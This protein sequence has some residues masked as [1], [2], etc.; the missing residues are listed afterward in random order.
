MC[1]P[2]NGI[3]VTVNCETNCS[4]WCPRV[5]R[6]F[7]CCFGCTG[8]R[9]VNECDQRVAKA[10]ETALNQAEERR[11]RESKDHKRKVGKRKRSRSSKSPRRQV[12]QS[13][14]YSLEKM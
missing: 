5:L 11:D 14:R 4:K 13:S 2:Q 9:E 7:C 6:M 1:F 10:V 8:R 3:S 12:N